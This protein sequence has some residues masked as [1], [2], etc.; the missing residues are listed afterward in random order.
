[1]HLPFPPSNT[2]QNDHKSD[3]TILKLYIHRLPTESA[4]SPHTRTS[5]VASPTTAPSD[6][7]LPA[8]DDAAEWEDAGEER[9]D[10]SFTDREVLEILRDISLYITSRDLTPVKQWVSSA[11]SLI[12][13][14]KATA[15]TTR[16]SRIVDSWT[17]DDVCEWLGTVGFEDA[18]A[19][20]RDHDITGEVLL[21]L[22]SSELKDMG[23]V[24]TGKRIKLLRL[25]GKI[26][27]DHPASPSAARASTATKS[28]TVAKSA[29]P[30]L[31]C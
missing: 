14:H 31:G 11:K 16:P 28:A 22:G 8:V 29:E 25:V 10:G 4:E 3:P 12:T 17:V 26:K 19:S 21:A 23:I 15:I 6:T 30:A 5:S 2:V 27:D 7:P 18:V 9:F 13:A 1:M 20:F 24:S